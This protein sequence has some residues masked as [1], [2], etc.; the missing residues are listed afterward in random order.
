MPSSFYYNFGSEDMKGYNKMDP[1]TSVQGFCLGKKQK[2][3]ILSLVS[4]K[5]YKIMA[6]LIYFMH[7]DATMNTSYE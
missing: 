4:S 6:F 5:K 1:C 2:D 7:Y 3:F